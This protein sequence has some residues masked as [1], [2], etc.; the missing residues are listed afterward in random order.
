MTSG[1]ETKKSS[2]I[3]PGIFKLTFFRDGKKVREKFRARIVRQDEFGKK[4]QRVQD[5]DSLTAARRLKRE[6]ED[7]FKAGGEKLIDGDRLTFGEV[8]EKYAAW[9]IKPPEYDDDTAESR[10][11]IAGLKSYRAAHSH[12]KPLI[13]CFQNKRIKSITYQDIESYKVKRLKTPLPNGGRRKIASVNRELERMR[14]IFNYAKR[15][16]WITKNPFEAGEP[17]ISKANEVKRDRILTIEEEN[18]LL[19]ACN[20]KRHYLKPLITLL[21]DTGMRTGEAFKL[22]WKYVDFENKVITIISSNSKTDQARLIPLTTTR[23]INELEKL[24]EAK[25]SPDDLVFGIR[26]NIKRAW[27]SILKETGFTNLRLHDLR[28]HATSSMVQSGIPQTEIMKITGHSQM[29]TFQRYNNQNPQ[30]LRDL[31]AIFQKHKDEQQARFEGMAS[32][33]RG[34]DEEKN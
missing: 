33:K 19:E 2:K 22:Q 10:K 4:I 1:N 18:R 17:L 30:R 26:T 15:E 20:G 16:G 6:L 9:K 3:E 5:A 29:T 23:L 14:T 12:I 31:A 11:K 8:A 7:E 13:D 24:Y 21:L 28:H 25:P 32:E 34:D 27:K